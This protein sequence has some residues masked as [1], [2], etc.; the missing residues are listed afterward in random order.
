M[1]APV[2][3]VQLV[4]QAPPVK[5]VQLLVITLLSTAYASLASQT[6]I[7]ALIAAPVTPV[8]LVLQAPPVTPV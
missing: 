2:T 3:P 1:A 6:A 4:I 5:P 7:R 8:Q